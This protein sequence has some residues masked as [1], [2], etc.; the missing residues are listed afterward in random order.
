MLTSI[1]ES[2]DGKNPNKAKTE[3]TKN[4][5]SNNNNKTPQAYMTCI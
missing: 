3:N 2:Q 1:E 4:K 5:T